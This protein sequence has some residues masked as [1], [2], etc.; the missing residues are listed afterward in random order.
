MLQVLQF[1]LK[2][3][4]LTHK[5]E[6][7]ISVLIAHS[8]KRQ[9]PPSSSDSSGSGSRGSSSSSMHIPEDKLHLVQ[10][11]QLSGIEEGHVLWGQLA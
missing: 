1:L 10:L 5:Q 11:G 7:E 3:T 2:L 6:A 8:L 4:K 9:Q